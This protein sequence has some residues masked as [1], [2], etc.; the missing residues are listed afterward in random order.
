MLPFEEKQ[1]EQWGL[2]RDV[3]FKGQP[4]SSQGSI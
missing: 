1:I 3:F 4:K 2:A